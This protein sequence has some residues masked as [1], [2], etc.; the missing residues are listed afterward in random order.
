MPT[1]YLSKELIDDKKLN[2]MVETTSTRSVILL[3]PSSILK[4]KDFLII[5]EKTSKN[6]FVHFPAFYYLQTLNP[7]Q[8]W[9]F[10]INSII[11]KSNLQGSSGNLR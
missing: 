4:I 2:K 1:I 5:K 8:I 7:S 6:I 9:G 11:Q 3:N 10:K